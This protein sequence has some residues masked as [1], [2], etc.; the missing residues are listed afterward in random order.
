MTTLF[1]KILFQAD[2]TP[3][4]SFLAPLLTASLHEALAAQEAAALA[5]AAA[6]AE[7]VKTT[8]FPKILF[9]AG[10]T[11]EGKTLPDFTPSAS[12]LAPLLT[13]S[14]HEAL[15]AQEAAA[16]AAAAA[17]AEAVMTILLPKILFQADFTPSTSFL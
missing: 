5:A 12:F 8:L 13:A 15:A 7:A 9:Q 1:P 3:S 16:L 4:A 2:F 6:A 14:L 11:R 17:T 10:F